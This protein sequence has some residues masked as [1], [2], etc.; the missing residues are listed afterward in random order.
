[1][2]EGIFFY[3]P[4]NKCPLPHLC[5]YSN[6]SRDTFFC[7]IYFF[8]P[9]LD[10][11]YSSIFF[12]LNIRL[13]IHCNCEKLWRHINFSFLKLLCGHISCLIDL[14]S[15]LEFKQVKNYETKVLP[16]NKKIIQGMLLHQPYEPD[17]K[18]CYILLRRTLFKVQDI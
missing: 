17:D 11:T 18:G 4:G 12:S 3:V 7:I 2:P 9:L 14:Q 15:L 13:I 6:V 16:F 1:M 10:I 5:G 8:L